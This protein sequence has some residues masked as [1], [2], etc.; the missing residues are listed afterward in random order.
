MTSLLRKEYGF[1]FIFCVL[2]PMLQAATPSVSVVSLTKVSETRVNRTDSDFVFKVTVQNGQAA[3]T[4][5]SETLISAGSGTTIIDGSVL[6]GNL[7]ANQSATPDDT[8]TLRQNRLLAFDQTK[9]VWQTGGSLVATSTSTSAPASTSSSMPA[10]SSSSTSSY[11]G[12]VFES[13]NGWASYGNNNLGAVGTT[14]GAA[15]DAAHTFTVRNRNELL[16]ALYGSSVTIKTNGSF[17]GTLDNTPKMI[18]VDGTISLNVN[19]DLVEQT[20]A[21]YVCPIDGASIK[22]A[23]D[24]NDY[25]T[26]YDP[27]GAWGSA[28]L[29]SGD[30]ETA[31]VCAAAKQKAVVKFKVGSNTSIIGLNKNAKIIHGNLSL[32]PGNDN[33]IIRNIAFEDAFDFFPQWDPTDSG[34]RWNSAYDNISVEGA[35]HVWIDHVS[36]SDG[37]RHDKLFPPVYAAPFNLPE[38]KVQH[39]DGAIDVTKG[40][41]YVTLSYNYIHDHDKTHLVGSSDTVAADNGP[42]FL[43]ITLHH[44]LFENVTQRL[45]RVRMGQ[46]HIYN[47]YYLG[48]IKPTDAG[49][50]YGFSTGMATGQFGKIFAENNSFTIAPSSTGVAPT[51]AQLH[52]VSFKADTTTINKCTSVGGNTASDCQTLFYENGAV[53]NNL[54]VNL[55]SAAQNTAASNNLVL[56]DASQFWNPINF[57]PYTL[58]ASPAVEVAVMAN[59]GAGN[60]MACSNFSSVSSAANSS[61]SSAVASSPSN[62]AATSSVS[63]SVSSSVVTSS[64]ASSI[65]SI[66]FNCGANIYA[67]DDFENGSGLWDLKPVGGPDG[68]FAIASETSGNHVLGY[69]AAS[70][71]GVLATSKAGVMVTV[72]TADYYVEAR[73]RP[74][75]NSTTGNKFLSLLGRYQD[76]NN[77]YAIDLNV[78]SSTAST[79]VEI[80]KMVAGTLTRLKQTKKA[81]AM[82]AQFYTVRL[83]MLG[84]NL[85]A[86]LDGEKISTIADTSLTAK[87]LIGLYTANKSF[88]IDDVKIGDANTKPVQL[89]LNP[90]STTWSAEAGDAPYVTSVTALTSDGVTADTFNVQSSDTNVVRVAINGTSVSL[91]PVAA[92]TASITFTSGSDSRV[93]RT[94]V[95]TIAPQFI[96]PTTVYNTTHNVLPAV[97]ETAA[98]IDGNLQIT[99]DSAPTLGSAGSIRIFKKSDDTLVDTISLSGNIDSL[100]YTGQSNLRMVNSQLLR[101]NGNTL[102]I[103]PHNNKLVYG[104]EYYVAIA[105]GAVTGA[106]FNGTPFTGIGKAGNWSFTT[107]ANAPTG[108][109]FVV[110]DNG[111]ADFRSVQGALNFVMQTVAKATPATI[112]VKNGSYEELLYLRGK[113]NLT[114]QGESREGV[115]IFYKNSEAINSGT[116]ASQTAGSPAGGRS[117]FLVETSD[118]LALNNLTLKNTTLRSAAA[119]QAE[120]I[121]FNNDVGRLIA[122]NSNFFSE[123]DTLQLKGYNWFY[124]CLVA[125]NVDFIWGGSHVALFENS[126]IRTVGDTTSSTSGG[127]VLQARVTSAS[128]KGFVFLNSK[129]THGAGPG[130][131]AGD[132]PVG[133]TYLARSGGSATYFDN[134]VF[135]NTQM[136]DHIAARGW[137]GGGVN[138]Q[139]APNPVTATATSGWREYGSMDLNGNPLDLSNRQDG[140]LLSASD[141]VS[142]FATRAQ[143]FSAYNSGAGW[144]PE[145]PSD[146]SSSSS[147]SVSSSAASSVASNLQTSS[148]ASSSIT[149][150]ATSSSSSSVASSEVVSSS[151]ASSSSSSAAAVITKVW[152]F[153]SSAYAAADTNLF[154]ATYNP[155]ADNGIKVTGGEVAVD[156]LLFNSTATNVVRYRPA[157]SANNTSANAIWN[158][159][160]S[161]FT[162]NAVMMPAVGGDLVSLRTYIAIPVTSGAAFTININYKQTSASG[163]AGKV[164]LAGSDNKVLVVKDA[165]IST[166]AAT[167]DTISLSVPAGHNYTS[168]KIIYGREGI[169]SGGVNIIAMERVQ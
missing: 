53:L 152:G 98:Y 169:S 109:S 111:P 93:T 10:T 11:T 64:S 80:H 128:D 163:T 138:S 89:T 22:V 166:A 37:D 95:A 27:N 46:V 71:G 146:S 9:L 130:P 127:Y 15:A 165:S 70:V 51:I 110:D 43:K 158:T 159:N 68:T 105:N 19:A 49:R 12:N 28:N 136:D 155:I 84:S 106:S 118:L 100:G 38:M 39:H 107:K 117:V 85:T 13:A 150:A 112:T 75:T 18:Y 149:S 57:Y 141:V 156:G 33:I 44:N 66:A 60:C 65:S 8:I 90:Y 124:N 3:A 119:S 63:N 86:Y 41:N 2:A 87:G 25:K 125:G 82:D 4:N 42:Q 48:Q 115:V 5:V 91:T 113:D 79:Q 59:A 69:T 45:P 76:A 83:E 101:V 32:A 121:Y 55:M 29:P 77:W 157:G 137:A 35:T 1:G 52:T 148:Q 94:I 114:I 23:Y 168:V 81:I 147:A 92:G 108:T 99:F 21:D 67:C 129:L 134:I 88:Q 73:I 143:I 6:A 30:L 58:D 50:E 103:V 72:P 40:S 132:V 36:V 102:T 56:G 16:R 164:A 161:F 142:N 78:Q 54:A 96:Q 31:R 153:D 145:V 14:G 162:S 151:S 135:V 97:G 24:F 34:G 116:G 131:L 122:T 26:T 126:E 160:G 104:T 133:A 47:N 120:V 74:M 167:G 123:Q 139:P 144:N 20:E 61:A 17:S 62:S 154:M 140:Y 7:G